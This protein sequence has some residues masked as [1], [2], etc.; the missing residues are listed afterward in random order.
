MPTATK[1]KPEIA[2]QFEVPVMTHGDLVSYWPRG[3]TSNHPLPALVIL[4]QDSKN[5]TL[6]VW[7]PDGQSVM[8][9]VKHKDD[10]DLTTNHSQRAGCWAI[11]VIKTK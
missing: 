5:L 6:H 7:A 3:I 8:Q 4:D 10:P 9:G 1:K 2:E 11:R